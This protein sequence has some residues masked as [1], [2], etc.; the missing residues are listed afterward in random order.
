MSEFSKW[1]PPFRSLSRRP[2]RRRGVARGELRLRAPLIHL[3]SSD[4]NYAQDARLS[5]SRR[6]DDVANSDEPSPRVSHSR[7]CSRVPRSHT[8]VP[9]YLSRVTPA[10]LCTESAHHP[11]FRL[12]PFLTLTVVPALARAIPSASCLAPYRTPSLRPAAWPRHRSYVKSC[13]RSEERPQHPFRFTAEP[14]LD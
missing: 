14:L 11:P 7:E 3:A 2:A 10:R 8:K 12:W 1:R 5:Q 6:E 9:P 13:Q 4:T